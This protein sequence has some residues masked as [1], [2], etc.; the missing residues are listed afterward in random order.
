MSQVG[1]AYLK[2]IRL[3]AYPLLL[4]RSPEAHGIGGSDSLG[5]DLVGDDLVGDKG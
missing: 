4:V 3:D 1:Q 5:D 2:G